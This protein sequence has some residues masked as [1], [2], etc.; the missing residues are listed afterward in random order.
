[1]CIGYEVMVEVYSHVCRHPITL[2]P[3][4]EKSALPLLDCLCAFVRNKPGMFVW[5]FH[6]ISLIRASLF[7]PI[8][9]YLGCYGYVVGI[10]IR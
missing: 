8:P 9:H 1:M 3:F 2:V 4:V 10:N 6:S 5:L 7:P